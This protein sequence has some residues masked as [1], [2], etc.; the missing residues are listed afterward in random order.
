MKIREIF[1]ENPEKS[2]KSYVAEP[3]AGGSREGAG[4]LGE[5]HDYGRVSVSHEIANP[6]KGLFL[7]FL[8]FRFG[9]R[10]ERENKSY[11]RG[12]RK[13]TKRVV[14]KDPRRCAKI[15]GSCYLSQIWLRLRGLT[16]AVGLTM[17]KN[18]LDIFHLFTGPMDNLYLWPVP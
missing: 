13:K 5:D 10:R 6:R 3:R 8:G 7:W 2:K 12:E 14:R 15:L 1:P 18:G 11:R 16:S 9:S 4:E 17:G